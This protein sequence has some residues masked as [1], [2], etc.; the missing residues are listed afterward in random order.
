MKLPADPYDIKARYAPGLIVA[1]PFLITLWTSFHTE[2]Q[3]LSGPL[4]GAISIII[5]YLLSVSVR[6]CGKRIEEKLWKS[7]GG[8]PSSVIVSWSDKRLGDAL[9]AKYHKMAERVLGMPMPDMDLEKADSHESL[10]LIDQA[11]ARIKG[12]LRQCD[13]DGLWSVVN[14]EYGFARNLYGSR[15]LWLSISILMTAASAT[16][17]YLSYD[18][19]KLIGLIINLLNLFC[20]VL[21][22][23][24]V[25]PKL[26]KDIGFRYAEHAWESFCN[27]AEQSV[28]IENR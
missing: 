14:A 20:C 28:K 23:W 16:L 11:F 15:L 22:G 10:Y 13:K 25:L 1:L 24:Y 3:A 9:K 19:L 2:A 12:I 6:F 26:A 27:I 7:W 4:G 5:W 8:A 21:V 17:V 18:N